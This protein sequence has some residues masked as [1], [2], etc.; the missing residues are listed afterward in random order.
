MAG[1]HRKRLILILTAAVIGSGFLSPQTSAAESAARSGPRILYAD[2]LLI[3]SPVPLQARLTVQSSDTLV[4]VRR[5][6]IYKYSVTNER[7]ARVGV[8]RF[9][10]APV[11]VPDSVIVPPGW[12]ASFEQDEEGGTV[13]WTVADTSTQPPPGREE[14]AAWPNPFEIQPGQTKVFGLFCRRPPGPLVSFHAE[15][16]D[17]A[18]DIYPDDGANR[19]GAD[20]LPA[21]GVRGGAVGPAGVGAEGGEANAER[22]ALPPEPPPP[23][24]PSGMATIFFFLPRRAE[25]RVSVHDSR[26]RPVK[27]LIQGSLAGGFHSITWNGTDSKGIAAAGGYSFRLFVDG[28]RAGQRRV[29]LRHGP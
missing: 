5:T 6:H 2:S 11:A 8:C 20:A 9:A 16:F 1:S 13:V 23:H 25:V 18:S 10:L 21:T 17:T 7:S 29:A 22:A 28:M 12:T 15:V 19:D 26:G 3:V 14:S 4:P 24:G 27:G